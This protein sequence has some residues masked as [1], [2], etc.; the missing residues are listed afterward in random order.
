[1]VHQKNRSFRFIQANLPFWSLLFVFD[2]FFR[3]EVDEWIP[4]WGCDNLLKQMK[5]IRELLEPDL[6]TNLINSFHLHNERFSFAL[7]C[8]YFLSKMYPP[9]LSPTILRAAQISYPNS[10]NKSS[11]LSSLCKDHNATQWSVRRALLKSF[12]L[13]IYSHLSSIYC[14]IKL[15]LTPYTQIPQIQKVRYLLLLEVIIE[16]IFLI[17]NL[18][19][20]NFW[21][22]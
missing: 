13:L 11:K 19:S 20:S 9:L 4:Y 18:F 16:G 6:N 2:L 21:V 15:S 7:L 5:S 10:K 8:I 3:V 12:Y 17:F 22:R 14:Q 1:M